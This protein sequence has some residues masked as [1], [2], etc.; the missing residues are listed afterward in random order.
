[1]PNQGGLSFYGL[2]RRALPDVLLENNSARASGAYSPKVFL[3][4]QLNRSALQKTSSILFLNYMSAG[5]CMK[6][7]RVGHFW[8]FLQ[9]KALQLSRGF[10]HSEFC[11]SIGRARTQIVAQWGAYGCSCRKAPAVRFASVCWRFLPR[12]GRRFT[13]GANL[14][15]RCKKLTL[16]MPEMWR[17]G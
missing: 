13:S 5:V 9:M 8:R 17:A 4:P 10:S 6:V 16:R 14:M 11:G 15:G 1:M 7:P 2:I 12:R 3:T